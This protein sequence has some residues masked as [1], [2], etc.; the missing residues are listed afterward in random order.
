MARAKLGDQARQR[1]QDRSG[2]SAFQFCVLNKR[3]SEL[4]GERGRKRQAS[5][6]DEQIKYV[7]PADRAQKTNLASKGSRTP[8]GARDGICL[9]ERGHS[10]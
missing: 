4:R 1:A 2:V 7:S 6:R 3:V 10:H 5:E 8:D 9:G